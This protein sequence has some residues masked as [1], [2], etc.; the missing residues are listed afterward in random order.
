MSCAITPIDLNTVHAVL[1]RTRRRRSLPKAADLAGDPLRGQR[2]GLQRN[3]KVARALHA[4]LAMI[5]EHG[6]A[7]DQ[8]VVGLAGLRAVGAR[9]NN[10]RAV[11]NRT[12][13]KHRRVRGR[14]R[15]D[16]VGVAGCGFGIGRSPDIDAGKL[17][18]PPHRIGE[19]CRTR[20]SLAD[21]IHALEASHRAEIADG[22]RRDL[23]RAEHRKPV[24]ARRRQRIGCRRQ[25]RR[26][27]VIVEHRGRDHRLRHASH[28]VPKQ[29]HARREPL[30]R[31][32]IRIDMHV[33]LHRERRAVAVPGENQHAALGRAA[34]EVE[35]SG[36]GHDA[37]CVT[38]VGVAHRGDRRRGLDQALD[39]GF[40]QDAHAAFSTL[41]PAQQPLFGGRRGPE[42]GQAQR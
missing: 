29:H 27:P 16:H 3:A 26:G 30:P 20:R 36:R 28:R 21:D 35:P 24:D 37:R 39:I 33:R 40:A 2:A 9:Q 13:G 42:H 8:V 1:R 14:H 34:S 12:A 4:A 6:G 10:Q 32:R 18:Q 31:S 11:A 38:A 22:R 17:R 25:S 41:G 19:R 15:D 5:D 23:A 7:G